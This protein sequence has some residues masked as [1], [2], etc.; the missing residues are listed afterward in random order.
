MKS[1]RPGTFRGS[2]EARHTRLTSASARTCS[3]CERDARD[4]FLAEQIVRYADDCAFSDTGN[5]MNDVGDLGRRE[6]L[7][8]PCRMMSFSRPAM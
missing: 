1:T 8:P 2:S 3:G 6:L 5:G 4:D 7:S